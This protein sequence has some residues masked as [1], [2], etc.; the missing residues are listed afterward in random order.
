MVSKVQAGQGHFLP[1]PSSLHPRA[2]V[3]PVNINALSI[4]NMTI[5]TWFWN[6]ASEV[7]KPL[8]GVDHGFMMS[9]DGQLNVPTEAR[10]LSAVNTASGHPSTHLVTTLKVAKLWWFL[11]TT[12]QAMHDLSQKWLV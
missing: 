3:W 2:K 7:F 11:K 12:K 4:L 8:E 9:G 10:K 6:A 1:L 5:Q